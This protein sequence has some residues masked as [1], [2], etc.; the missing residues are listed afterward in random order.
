M[1]INLN[2]AVFLKGEAAFPLQY[3]FSIAMM[4]FLLIDFTAFACRVGRGY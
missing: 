1:R 4:E 2:K 3:S